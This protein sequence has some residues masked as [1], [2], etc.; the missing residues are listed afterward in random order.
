[1]WRRAL[2]LAPALVVLGCSLFTSLDGLHDDGRDAGIEDGRSTTDVPPHDA[3]PEAAESADAGPFCAALSPPATLCSDFDTTALPAEWDRVSS[4]GSGGVFVDDQSSRSAPRSAVATFTKSTSGGAGYLEKQLDTKYTTRIAVDF[5]MRI[6]SQDS[7]RTPLVVIE[8]SANGSS[9]RIFFR[10]QKGT[11]FEVDEA[12]T[13]DGGID[14][15]Q[16]STL[17]VMDAGTPD[18]WQH[19]TITLDS[20][21]TNTTASLTVDGAQTSKSGF[22]A[23]RYSSKPTVHLGIE[24]LAAADVMWKIRFDNVV[25]RVE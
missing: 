2:Y 4:Y 3:G 21:A 22:R 6:E 8:L 5:D 17:P 18:G 13:T 14:Y 16:T 11:G 25:I 23:H 24:Y 10:T 15:A 19:V 7:R 20:T 1:M 12:A 9:D